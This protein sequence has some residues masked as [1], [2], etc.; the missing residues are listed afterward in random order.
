MKIMGNYILYK[1]GR[2]PVCP[3]SALDGCP[4][5]WLPKVF[6]RNETHGQAL[7]SSTERLGG[8]GIVLLPFQKR[9]D[10]GRRD[11]S[12]SVTEFGYR[13]RRW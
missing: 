3:L 12:H 9:L 7:C 13:R 11:E 10:V 6:D 4:I 8:G 1:R 2:L 5:A